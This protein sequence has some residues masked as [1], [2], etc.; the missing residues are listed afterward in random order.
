[1]KVLELKVLEVVV[2]VLVRVEEVKVV[3]VKVVEVVVRVE[4]VKVM[5]VVVCLN[6]YTLR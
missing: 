1:M 5:E 4:E 3:V 2:E 6:R